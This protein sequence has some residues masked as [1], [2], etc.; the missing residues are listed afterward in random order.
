MKTFTQ[1]LLKGCEIGSWLETLNY[2]RRQTIEV[3]VPFVIVADRS[4]QTI[5]LRVRQL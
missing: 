1:R 3:E 2:L 5:R 4:G